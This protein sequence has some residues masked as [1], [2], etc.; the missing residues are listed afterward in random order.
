M[1]PN[2][3]ADTFDKNMTEVL[4][5]NQTFDTHQFA[6]TDWYLSPAVCISRRPWLPGRDQHKANHFPFKDR[7]RPHWP[8]SQSWSCCPF[9]RWRHSFHATGADAEPAAAAAQELAAS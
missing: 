6:N 7:G 8:S 3:A 4:F 5:P 1:P 9:R 2:S